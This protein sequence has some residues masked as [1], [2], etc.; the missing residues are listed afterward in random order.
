[1]TDYERRKFIIKYLYSYLKFEQWFIKKN[2][3]TP[4]KKGN[5]KL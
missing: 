4:K 3:K 2:L 5:Q 1:M